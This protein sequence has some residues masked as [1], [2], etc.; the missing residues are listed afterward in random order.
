MNKFFSMLMA[1]VTCLTVVATP[2]TAAAAEKDL[3]EVIPIVS[4]ALSVFDSTASANTMI[5]VR[6]STVNLGSEDGDIDMDVG[7]SKTVTSPDNYK[8]NTQQIKIKFKSSHD[9][10]VK[11]SLYDASGNY[12]GGETKDVGT[13]LNKTWTFPNLT[14]SQTYYFTVKNLGQRDVTITGSVT[15]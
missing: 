15:D 4:G 5:A 6:A 10:T 8:T 14:S 13:I 11:V 7:A 2:A 3:P 1:V 12:M 9:I